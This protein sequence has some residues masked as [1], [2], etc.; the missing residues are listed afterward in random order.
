MNMYICILLSFVKLLF[1]CLFLNQTSVPVSWE[2]GY[3]Y[4]HF[5]GRGMKAGL[6]VGFTFL[7]CFSGL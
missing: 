1:V 7:R 5:I 4:P 6:L 3:C 2:I